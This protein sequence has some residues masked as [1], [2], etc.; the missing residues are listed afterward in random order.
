MPV[1]R[2]FKMLLIF[3]ECSHNLHKPREFKSEMQALKR[4]YTTLSVD[5]VFIWD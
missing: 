5:T 4:M 1:L 3:T 2:A